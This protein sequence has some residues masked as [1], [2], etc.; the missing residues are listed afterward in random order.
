MVVKMKL[1][2][3][4]CLAFSALA[5]APAFAAAP[6]PTVNAGLHY[7]HTRG[8]IYCGTETGNKIL[9]WRDEKGNWQG[10]DVE[11]C[12]MLST[13]VSAEA[14]ESRWCRFFQTRCQTPFTPTKSTL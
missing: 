4:L 14:T 8:K 10:I 12:K 3:W 1:K 11:L 9:A 2:L 13:A 6:K 5:A 7:I